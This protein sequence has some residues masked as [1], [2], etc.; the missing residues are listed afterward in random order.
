MFQ[1]RCKTEFRPL[2]ATLIFDFGLISE[3][4][5]PKSKIK[6]ANYVEIQFYTEPENFTGAILTVS[7]LLNLYTWTKIN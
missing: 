7:S 4:L 5:R 3:L 1:D 6:V 2:L